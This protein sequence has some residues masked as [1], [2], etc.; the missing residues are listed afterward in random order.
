MKPIK[1][2]PTNEEGERLSREIEIRS[3][4][5]NSRFEKRQITGMWE[6]RGGQDV[7]KLKQFLGWM[8]ILWDRFRGLGSVIWKD[9]T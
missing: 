2:P 8:M 7:P 1:F 5:F 6:E 4:F 3:S 9:M